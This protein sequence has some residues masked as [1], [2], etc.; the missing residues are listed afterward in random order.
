[1]PKNNQGSIS[2]HFSWG[3][4]FGNKQSNR[5]IYIASDS[6]MNTTSYSILGDSFERTGLSHD[7]Q[8]IL[9]GSKNFQ[10]VEIEVYLIN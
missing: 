4:V 7:T 9:A 6:N 10:T 3:T 1:M 2:C 8:F 5:D